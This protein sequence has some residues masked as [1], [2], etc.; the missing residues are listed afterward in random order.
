MKTASLISIL[1]P[2]RV[3]S[4]GFGAR[5]IVFLLAWIVKPGC[6]SLEA[7]AQV[8]GPAGFGAGGLFPQIAVDPAD[9]R[10]VYLASDVSGLNKS[11]NYG[12]TWFKMNAGLDSREVSALAID[13]SNS[14]RLWVGTPLGLYAS[15]NAGAAWSLVATNITCYKHVNRRGIAINRY[16]TIL[17]ASHQI[18]TPTGETPDVDANVNPER[19]NLLGQLYRSADG[20][21]TWTLNAQLE[22]QF[23]DRYRR[24]R[25]VVFDP[26]DDNQAFLL[27]EGKGGGVFKSVDDGLTWSCFTNGLPAGLEWQNLDVGSNVVYATAAPTLPYR[28]S[29]VSASWQLLTNGIASVETASPYPVTDVIRVSPADD[30]VVYLGQA[31]WPHVVYRSRNA[32][33]DWKG[34]IVPNEQDFDTNNAPF[35]TWIDPYQAPI[36]MAIDP[37][38][39]SRVYYTTW[40]GAWRSDNGGTNWTEKDVGS[41]NTVCTAI[42]ADGDTLF[43]AHMDVG[44]CRSRDHGRSWLPCFPAPGQRGIG[45]HAWSLARGPEG[46]L[47]AGIT[48]EMLLDP[49][50]PVTPA[51]CSSTN[52]GVTWQVNTNGIFQPPD[53]DIL[54]SVCLATHPRQAGTLYLGVASF[55]DNRAIHR[56]TDYGR[57]WAPLPKAPGAVGNRNDRRVK[58][59]AV[60]AAG[61]DRL[62]AGLYWDGLWHSDDGGV[63]WAR[64]Q[65][66]GVNLDYASV[67]QIVPLPDGRIF[68]AFDSGVYQSSD[69]GQTFSAILTNA[70][71]SEDSLEYAYSVAF[72]PANPSDLFVSTGKLYPVW[73]NRGSVWRSTNG[74]STW[75]DITGNL[76]I[77]TVAGFACQD[78]YLYAAVLGANVYRC[79]LM[80]DSPARPFPQHVQYVP[81]AIL[82]TATQTDLDAA[83]GRFYDSWKAQYLEPGCVPGQYYI[84][85]SVDTPPRVTNSISISEGHG[86]GM[87]ITALMAGYDQEAKVHFDGL[88][89][90]FTNHFSA[91]TPWVMSWN[92][93]GPK[94]ANTPDADSASDGDLDIAYA[95]LLADR[96]WGSAGNINYLQAATN[97]LLAALRADFNPINHSV[98]LG[99]WA[100]DPQN[101]TDYF[102]T[103]SSDFVVNHFA[104]FHAATG[105]ATWLAVRNECYDLVNEMQTRFSPLTGLLPDF[106]SH[107]DASPQPAPP[108]FLEGRYDGEYFYN[109]CRAPWRLALDYLVGGDTRALTAVSRINQWIRQRT[110]GDPRQINAGYFIRTGEPLPDQDQNV[111]PFNAPL[112]V[113]AMVSAT[114]QVWLDALWQDLNSPLA[115]DRTYYGNNLTMLCMLALSGNWWS[116]LSPGSAPVLTIG[117]TS[118]NTIEISWPAAASGFALQQSPDLQ[119]GNWTTVT[120]VPAVIDGKS[121]LVLPL[122]SGHGFYRLI[123]RL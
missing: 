20:G 105:D 32:G 54:N 39:P 8:W 3:L 12:E 25:A 110:G 53:F 120:N 62:F 45:V 30:A 47:Y 21:M 65:G 31:A 35:Q 72:N 24:F 95:L 16:G 6:G 122:P 113:S 9:S 41:Q 104:A 34:N 98:L 84:H 49:S 80:V 114:N 77:K 92:Q 23:A 93:V 87:L 76:P 117:L 70:N 74:G 55:T 29:K 78:G 38:N 43:S 14:Q 89:G 1:G 85:Y 118:A 69:H 75:L 13:P 36:D 60:D 86:Y 59:L 73:Y 17:V 67:Q 10:I 83:T 88:Y 5:L 37:S 107:T 28:S 108:D 106:I 68:A 51:V 112:A 121:R 123:G 97:V 66:S 99:D 4:G 103:R 116:P 91:R 26:R 7:T 115:G 18:A 56:S 102:A 71:W 15:T 101:P 40:W 48:T 27:V 19:A 63:N 46:T 79:Q 2:L 52:G 90:Y 42:L 96:Q 111:L 44:V 81:G 109:A 22:S 100:S 94:C 33:E 64:A 11:T 119:P 61:T 50:V 82:P 58:C 57:T